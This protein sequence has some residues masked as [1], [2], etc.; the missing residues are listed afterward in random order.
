MGEQVRGAAPEAKVILWARDETE[1][2]VFEPGSAVPRR[3]ATAIPD[4]LLAS[5][6]CQQ[7]Q[8]GSDMPNVPDPWGLRRGDPRQVEAD[9]GGGDVHRQPLS[10]SHRAARS[11]RPCGSRT[12]RSS[13]GSTAIPRTPTTGRSWRARTSHTP[14]TATSRT[15]AACA[16]SC[17]SARAKALRRAQAALPAATDDSVA[18]F[19]ALAQGN[20]DGD[21]SVELTE[22]TAADK[23]DKTDA[24]YKLVVTSGLRA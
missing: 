22:E 19:R 11:T 2:E 8:K 20:V 9:R 3:V 5:S 23:A 17:A 16:G 4:A 24:T 6:T 13:R 15:A 7:R 1:M 18:P 12:G 10:G 14:S 21:I